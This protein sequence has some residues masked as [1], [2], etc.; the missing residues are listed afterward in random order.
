M[1]YICFFV[2]VCIGVLTKYIHMQTFLIW[3]R[4]G[5]V[6]SFL[7]SPWKYK[8]VFFTASVVKVLRH[9]IT[10]AW[11]QVMAAICLVLE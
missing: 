3:C 6:F 8:L 10:P 2:F 1:T 9:I 7:L 11:K 5:L 4:I